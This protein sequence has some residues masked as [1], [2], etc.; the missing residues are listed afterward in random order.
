M[1]LTELKIDGFGVWRGLEIHGLSPGLNVFYGPN[2]AGKTTLMQFARAVL[3]GFS[4][5]RWGR[6]LPPVRGGRGGGW[7]GASTPAGSFRISRI[8][9]DGVPLGDATVLAPDGT[10]Q[11][12]SQ[13]SSLLGDVDESIFNNVFAVGLGELQELGTLDGTAAARL[14]YDLSTGLDRV[15]LGEVL[16]ELDSSRI[17]LLGP[18]GKPSQIGELLAQ[19]D[20]LRAELDELSNLTTRHWRLAEDRDRLT[21][22][23]A[24]AEA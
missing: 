11:G 8:D 23:I 20:G 21:E 1:K 10:I 22:A 2:E 24:R 13:L 3:Y 17:R 6:Y 14:L 9:R 16:R 4:P 7:L 19:R 15:S 12:E 18:D 5:E